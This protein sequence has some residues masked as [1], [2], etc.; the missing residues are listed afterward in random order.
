MHFQTL[1]ALVALVASAQA[2]STPRNY[3]SH[4]KRAN[5]L[6]KWINRGG[7]SSEA[8]LPMR[9]GLRQ[10]NIDNGKGDELMGEV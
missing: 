3:V 10:P 5:P 8:I 2:L 6:K 4:E 9:I 1:T 7:V